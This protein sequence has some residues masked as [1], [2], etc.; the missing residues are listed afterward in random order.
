MIVAIANVRP[1][2]RSDEEWDMLLNIERVCF[3]DAPWT[4][5]DYEKLMKE[6]DAMAHL[7]VLANGTYAGCFWVTDNEITSLS[8]LPEYRGKHFGDLLLKNALLIIKTKGYIAATLDVDPALITAQRLY[9][10]YGFTPV[11][12]D[13]TFY[14]KHR[15]A[16]RMEKKL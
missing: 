6:S 2:D 4:R 10:K 8:V 14:S 13:P 15:G 16:I 1:F 11:S 9:I 5:K 7:L 12:Y 3:P